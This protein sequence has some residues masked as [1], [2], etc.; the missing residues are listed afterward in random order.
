[1]SNEIFGSSGSSVGHSNNNSS[2]G[3]SLLPQ[4]IQD[5]FTQYATQAGNQ[6]ATPQTSSYAPGPLTSGETTALNTINQGFAPT[7]DQINTSMNE[8]MN[9]FNADVMNQIQRQA[10]GADSAL[11]SQLSAAGQYGSNRAALGANDIAS[12][13]ATTLGSILQPQFQT[14]MNNALTTIPQLNAQSASAQLQ[15]GQF[16]QQLGLQ[17]AQAPVSAL[18]AY[19]SLLGVL[20]QTGGSVS[21]GTSDNRSSQG[22]GFGMF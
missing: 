2:S 21:S 1:M 7:Q 8:Q 18:S 14:A 12:Q 17:N 9:P 11:N 16:Q 15:G 4:Q 6:F 19:G 22:S 10:Y 13:Q 20:P 5:A 3:F